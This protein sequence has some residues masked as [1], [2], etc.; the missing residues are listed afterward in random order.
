MFLV[1]RKECMEKINKGKHLTKSDREIIEIGIKNGSSKQSIANTLG[2]DA[3][4]IGKEIKQHRTLAYKCKMSLECKNFKKCKFERNCKINCPNYCKYTCRRR[5]HSPG[6][7]NGCIN[8][9]S[10]RY[11][12]YRYDAD[13]A[14]NEYKDKLVNLRQGFNTTIEE[15]KTIGNTIYP[16]L[17]QGQSVEQ[18]LLAHTEIKQSVKTIYTYIESGIFKDVGIDISVLSLRRQVSRK[19]PKTKQNL[20]KQRQDR[21]YLKGRTYKDYENYINENPDVYVTEMDTVYNDV[22]NG[23]FIQTFKFLRFGFM[24]CVFHSEKTAQTMNDGVLLIEEILGE[25]LFSLVVNVLKTDRG[26]EFVCLK[27]IEFRQDGTRR[28]RVFY[29]DPMASCQKGS[30]ENKHEELRYICPKETDL[31]I[32]GLTDQNQMNLVTS[33]INSSPRK[34]LNGKSPIELI[35]FLMP[36][37]WQKLEEFGIKEIPKDEVILKPYLLKK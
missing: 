24:L 25:E 20:Y 10:C 21:S 12:K 23:P 30:L 32:L 31:Y 27:D 2:K 33:N 16:L 19:L 36:E 11:D 3:S 28:T 17:K 1:N 22:S 15:I 29:C 26:S 14:E 9:L 5:D 34:K 18:I 13:I 6:A 37:F 4:T 8:Y 7:C 35:K